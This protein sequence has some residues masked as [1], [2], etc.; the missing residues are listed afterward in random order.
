MFVM[1]EFLDIDPLLQRVEM[2]LFQSFVLVLVQF[3]TLLLLVFRA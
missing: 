1:L 2:L 3:W